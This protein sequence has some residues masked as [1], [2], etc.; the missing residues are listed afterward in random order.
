MIEIQALG[1]KQLRSF[2][3]IKKSPWGVL[4]RAGT[5]GHLSDAGAREMKG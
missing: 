2:I 1:E 4:H 3:L 5:A